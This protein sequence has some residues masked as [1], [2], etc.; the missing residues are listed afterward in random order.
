LSNNNIHPLIFFSLGMLLKLRMLVSLQSALSEA[1]SCLDH[2][3]SKV[4]AMAALKDYDTTVSNVC[5]ILNS[6]Q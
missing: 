1:I 6:N 5:R 2:E 3:P 4:A